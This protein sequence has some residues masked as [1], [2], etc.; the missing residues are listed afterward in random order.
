VAPVRSLTEEINRPIQLGSKTLKQREFTELVSAAWAWLRHLFGAPPVKDPAVV[1]MVART[2]W[3]EA[4]GE[5]PAGMLA[6]ACVIRN[7]VH[8]PRS[9]WGRDWRTV[10]RAE[11]QFSC[12]NPGDPNRAKLE[13]V[14]RADPAFKEALEIAERVVGEHEHDITGGATHYCSIKLLESNRRPEWAKGREPHWKHGGHAFFKDV[15]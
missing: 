3:G 10:C 1:D 15:P 4:R 9:R 7:R 8:D 6:V 5:G 12:W 2:I 14:T 11:R 13:A